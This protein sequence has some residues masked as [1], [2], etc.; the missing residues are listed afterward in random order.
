MPGVVL[1]RVE[2]HDGVEGI[3]L[4]ATVRDDTS[5]GH[6]RSSVEGKDAL[7]ASSRLIETTN[8]PSK[9]FF[10]EPTSEAR[11]VRA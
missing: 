11:R 5:E 10:P 6:A 8:K 1:P 4:E 7:E 3:E 9:V 2:A